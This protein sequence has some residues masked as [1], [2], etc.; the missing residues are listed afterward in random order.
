MKERLDVLSRATWVVLA[1]I[2]AI[3]PGSVLADPV[4]AGPETPISFETWK[5]VY[6]EIN[7]DRD[8]VVRLAPSRF[9]ATERVETHGYVGLDLI[10]GTAT[11]ELAKLDRAVDVWILD[12]KPGQ[13]K[14]IL[15][16]DGDVLI[17][18]GQLLPTKDGS[19]ARLAVDL[20]ADGFRGVAVDWVLV[21]A[22]G[23]HPGTSRLLYGTRH[24]N[25]TRYTRERLAREGFVEEA[26]VPTMKGA[27]AADH[28]RGEVINPFETGLL[29]SRQTARKGPVAE[30]AAVVVSLVPHPI[31]VRKGLVSEKV[32]IGGELFFRETFEGNNRSCGTCHPA[33]NNQT[34]DV[35]F[36]NL[37]APSDPLFVAEQRPPS[38][39]IS[40]LERPPLMR[41]FGLILENVDDL[42]DPNNRFL[43]RGV[44]HSLS[45]ATSINAPPGNPDVVN[46]T[47]W[48]GDGAPSPGRLREFLLGAVIQHYPKNS[49]DRVAKQEV[50][51]GYPF[52]FRLPTDDELDLTNE[53]MLNVGRTSELTLA[54]VALTD[55]NAD[56]GR[57]RFINSGCNGCHSDASANVAAGLNLNFFTGVERLPNPAQGFAGINFPLDGGFGGQ[58]E[59]NPTFDCDGDGTLD[60]F[61]DG[62]FN[63]VGLIESADTPPFFHN[64]VAATVEDAVAFY[65]AA[66]FPAPLGFTPQEVD[67]VGAFMRVINASFNA[68]MAKQRTL[69]VLN[70]DPDAN[71]ATTLSDYF[72]IRGTANR[73]ILLAA[74][75][76]EDAYQVLTQGPL[77]TINAASVQRLQYAFDGLGLA[78]YSNN[79]H[80]RAFYLKRVVTHL[81]AADTGLGSGM[82][83]ALGDGNLLF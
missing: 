66:P 49:L 18:L 44:P 1:F 75:E 48:S 45:M 39:P 67:N 10:G 3:C 56:A 11:I 22:A 81:M 2:L 15:A 41:N 58:G 61:G 68:Q 31:L 9:F 76:V 43:M 80:T 52:D 83:L 59:V 38:D 63:S 20:G 13:G 47:G 77:G 74:F 21:S 26:V 8:V 16:E 40:Q 27:A 51:P 46:H 42:S 32:F 17:H 64:N 70:I 6:D 23:T 29:A 55:A 71:A 54:N 5:A 78:F 73:L 30:K 14:S 62:Q 25:E 33:E 37:L 12:N 82:S 69:A 35:P 53:Y 79:L 28:H 34:I 57:T 72:G 19:P 60:C 50:P 24:V 65:Q 4:D 7:G 36:I